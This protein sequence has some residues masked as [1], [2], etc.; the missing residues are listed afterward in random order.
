MRKFDAR[1]N[2]RSSTRTR[3]GSMCGDCR[4]HRARL[5]ACQPDWLLDCLNRKRNA[6]DEIRKE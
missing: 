4:N 5:P 6:S 3:P 2:Y 1:V